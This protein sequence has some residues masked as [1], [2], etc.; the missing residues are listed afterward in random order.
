[1]NS[2]QML[3][4]YDAIGEMTP[5]Q[6]ADLWQEETAEQY[7]EMLEVLPPE[8][9]DGDAFMVGERVTGNLF[10][11]H[12]KVDDRYFWRPADI[13]QFNPAKYRREIRAKFPNSD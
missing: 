12:I 11:A 4:Y 5:A 3:E 6:L 7:E 1:M 2:K 13:Y 10:N 9:W 8:R